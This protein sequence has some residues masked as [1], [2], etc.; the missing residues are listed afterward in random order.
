MPIGYFYQETQIIQEKIQVS[1]LMI[2]T[3]IYDKYFNSDYDNTP[4][5]NLRKSVS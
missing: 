3:S 1:S 4:Y 5:D 2:D